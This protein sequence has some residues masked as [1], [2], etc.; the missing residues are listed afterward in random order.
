M[1]LIGLTGGIGMGKSTSADW[2]S[3]SGI[4]VVDT[5]VLAREVVAPGEP[6]LA[7]VVKLLGPEVLSCDG[8]LQ[9]REVAKR[10]FSEESL[11]KQL[12]AILHPRIRERWLAQVE[13]WKQDRRACGVVVIPL[14]YETGAEAYFEAVVCTA[15]TR[16]SQRERLLKRGWSD[17]DAMRRLQAQWPVEKKIARSHFVVWTEGDLET[18]AAQWKHVLGSLQLTHVL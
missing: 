14:L 5:D 17:Q 7:E 1:K 18:H 4:P 9:R 2:L 16:E 15:C 3:R 13:R 11:R 8:T 10:I 12:E 6:A